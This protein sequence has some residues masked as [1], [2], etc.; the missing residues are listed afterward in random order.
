MRKAKV[1]AY[2]L[3]NN[4]FKE[5]VDNELSGYFDNLDSLPDYRRGV[6]HSVGHFVSPRGD[7]MRNTPIK[8]LNLPDTIEKYANELTILDGIQ[9]L[10]SLLELE[11]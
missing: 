8:T 6:T 10:A 2:R 11:D 1:L 3:R 7:T 4:E 9:H 5:W